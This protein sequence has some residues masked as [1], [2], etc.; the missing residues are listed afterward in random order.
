MPPFNRLVIVRVL[1]YGAFGLLI[2][3]SVLGLVGVLLPE[4]MECPP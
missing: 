2:N 1:F 4:P 3:G